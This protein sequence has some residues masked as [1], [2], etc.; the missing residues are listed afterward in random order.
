MAPQTI[1]IAKNGLE[2]AGLRW[3][4]RR[5]GQANSAGAR[6]VDRGCAT[7]RRFTARPECSGPAETQRLERGHQRAG[8]EYNLEGE[9]RRGKLIFI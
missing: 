9:L 1:E 3:F 5:I 8:S 4:V 2:S 7:K 6:R